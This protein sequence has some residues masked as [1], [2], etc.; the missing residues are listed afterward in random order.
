VEL[1]R[2]TPK[3]RSVAVA[4]VPS[5][6]AV[7][8]VS[9]VIGRNTN[10]CVSAS[11]KNKPAHPKSVLVQFFIVNFAVNLIF[12]PQSYWNVDKQVF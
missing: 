6:I 5:F 12:I 7:S 11:S 3:F 9:A 8:S 4:A 1:A 2:K 10:C